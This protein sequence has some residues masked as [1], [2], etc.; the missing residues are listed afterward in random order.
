[1][2]PSLVGL[3]W[4]MTLGG[5][6]L[7]LP[8]CDPGWAVWEP[9][10]GN[11]RSEKPLMMGI[12]LF[13][14]ATAPFIARIEQGPIRDDWPVYERALTVILPM[15]TSFAGTFVPYL[16]PPRTYRA[17]EELKGVRLGVDKSGM[18]LGWTLTF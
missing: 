2:G 3:T 12:A 15:A 9:P 18:T 6:Y 14:A 10:E 4:G 1:M 13:A 5:A 7:S 16:F 17:A 8:K 11:V